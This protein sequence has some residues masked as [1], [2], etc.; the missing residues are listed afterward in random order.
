MDRDYDE[1]RDMLR[2]IVEIISRIE[3]YLGMRFEQFAEAI[4]HPE[5]A[6]VIGD[7][8]NRKFVIRVDRNRS[9]LWHP[10]YFHIIKPSHADMAWSELRNEIVAYTQRFK[11]ANGTELVPFDLDS[12]TA[13]RT[14]CS[15]IPQSLRESGRNLLLQRSFTTPS[16]SNNIDILSIISVASS[17]EMGDGYPFP[18][19]T[20]RFGLSDRVVLFWEKACFTTTSS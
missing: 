4:A 17:G 5:I 3:K 14:C 7:V 19:A 11:T 16:Q 8:A 2:R 1:P 18:A 13:L 6:H 20:L 15:L 9:I 10:G 12:W